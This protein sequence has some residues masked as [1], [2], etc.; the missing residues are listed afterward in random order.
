[1]FHFIVP[2]YL[3]NIH[4]YVK[5]TLIYKWIRGMLKIDIVTH[6]EGHMAIPSIYGSE[7]INEKWHFMWKTYKEFDFCCDLFW[8]RESSIDHSSRDKSF[9]VH[10]QCSIMLRLSHAKDMAMVKHG[11]T[12]WWSSNAWSPS[13]MAISKVTIKKS[14]TIFVVARKATSRQSMIIYLSTYFATGRSYKA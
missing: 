11:R 4:C 12:I 14:T 1:M 2:F 5:E 10:P 9:S 8:L 13:L 3:L 6:R 7:G